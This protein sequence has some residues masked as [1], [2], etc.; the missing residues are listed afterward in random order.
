MDTFGAWHR[1]QSAGLPAEGTAWREQILAKCAATADKH[2][3]RQLRREAMRQHE[4]PHDEDTLR[5]PY[6][7]EQTDGQ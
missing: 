5:A 3:K 4:I 7:K 1:T 6:E 2:A